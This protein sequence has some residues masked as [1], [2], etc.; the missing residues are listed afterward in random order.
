MSPTDWLNRSVSR[1]AGKKS[2]EHDEKKA[3]KLG[4]DQQIKGLEAPKKIAHAEAL[5][6]GRRKRE[7]SEKVLA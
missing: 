6:A 7:I 4:A 3:S 1:L 5:P 2:A